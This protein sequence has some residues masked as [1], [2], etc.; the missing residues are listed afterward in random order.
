MT[1]GNDVESSDLKPS[2][3]ACHI[4]HV[5][6]RGIRKLR[7]QLAHAVVSERE[8]AETGAAAQFGWYAAQAVPVHI[9]VGQLL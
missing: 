1:P 9:Q 2:P 8:H 3:V 5:Q 4:Q 6:L 7:R